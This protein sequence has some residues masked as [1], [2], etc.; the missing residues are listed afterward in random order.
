MIRLLKKIASVMSLLSNI[1][2]LAFLAPVL[3]T[4]PM[5]RFMTKTNSKSRR[6]SPAPKARATSRSLTVRKQA[7]ASRSAKSLSANKTAAKL[8]LLEAGRA[9]LVLAKQG[10]LRATDAGRVVLARA[11]RS[12]AGGLQHAARGIGNSG[13]SALQSVA[14]RITP[15]P[16]K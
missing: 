13:A 6:K 15:A 7:S 12:A 5:E 1:V 16:Q 9:T 3:L 8:A 14:D 11:T 10:T 2:S 4:R